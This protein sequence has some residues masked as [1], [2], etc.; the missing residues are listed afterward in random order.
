LGAA[1]PTGEPISPPLIS[2]WEQGN[3][4][5]VER[6]L[7]AYATFFATDRSVEGDTPRLLR[8]SDLTP[9]ERATRDELF[10]ELRSMRGRAVQA[11]ADVREVSAPPGGPWHFP[12][13]RPITIVSSEVPA[14]QRPEATPAHPTLAYGE[15]Y[16]YASID[17]LFELF[18]HIR[19]ANPL[20]DVAIRKE[21]E[22]VPDDY[23]THLV[24]V[25]GVDWNELTARLVGIVGV[26]VKQV[27]PGDDPAEAY[28]EVEDDGQSER[29]AA[30][31][32][33]Q[34]LLSD[35]G[36]FLRVPSPFNRKRT[37]TVCNGNYSLGTLGV[38][39]A[40][41]DK[42]FRDRNAAY[43]AERFAGSDTCSIVTRMF[44]LNEEE[45]VTPDWTNPDTRLYEWPA[46]S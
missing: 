25:G 32:S 5:P 36:H 14:E 15:M 21:R 23:A 44:I 18:G 43:L 2:S 17:A 30:E 34:T 29:F 33:G 13:G 16:S 38:V 31:I 40:L 7:R 11:E 28:F 27:S 46:R 12:D 4:V 24:V 39:R 10:D 6:W 26:P 45:V 1:G 22:L 9:D 8:L 20:A 41:T 42:W 35:V 19:A 3:A 37:L